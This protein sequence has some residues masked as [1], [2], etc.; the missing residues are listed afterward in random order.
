MIVC[1][2]EKQINMGDLESVR[3]ALRVRPLVPSEKAR[4]C[5]IAVE[6]VN[7][8]HQVVVNNTDPFTF[9]FVFDW[10]DTQEQVYNLSVSGK[11][12]QFN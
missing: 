8:Q 10:R 11:H 6:K 2:K 9:N 12:K 1:V 5:Q 4:G 3:V 7:G